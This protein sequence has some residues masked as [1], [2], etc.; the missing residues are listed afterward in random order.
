ML[1]YWILLMWPWLETASRLTYHWECNI[2]CEAQ[3]MNCTRELEDH[4]GDRNGCFCSGRRGLSRLIWQP[5]FLRPTTGAMTNLN[6]EEGY[7]STASPVEHGRL[8]VHLRQNIPRSPPIYTGHEAEASNVAAL[9][10]FP[11]LLNSIRHPTPSSH[12]VFNILRQ[13][14]RVCKN[15]PLGARE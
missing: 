11:H 2:R 5:L 1:A 6:L 3:Q 7:T 8:V 15:L 4:D 12:P 14:R 13:T 10:S 9:P